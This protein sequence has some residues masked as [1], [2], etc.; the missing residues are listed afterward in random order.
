LIISISLLWIKLAFVCHYKIDLN[1]IG[2]I[3]K[4]II[5]G[6]YFAQANICQTELLPINLLSKE[7]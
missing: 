6:I 1:N 4:K 7:I 2:L 5:G 3:S